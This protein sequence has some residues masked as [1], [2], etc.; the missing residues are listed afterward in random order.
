MVLCWPCGCRCAKGVPPPGGESYY[1]LKKPW[2]VRPYKKA[3]SYIGTTV[4]L[5]GARVVVVDIC[6]PGDICNRS[7]VVLVWSCTGPAIVLKWPHAKV[8]PP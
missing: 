4:L 7:W 3:W 6:N 5:A 1:P 8:V 2:S